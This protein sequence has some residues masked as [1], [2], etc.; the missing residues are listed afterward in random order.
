[1][2]STTARDSLQ[3]VTFDFATHVSLGGELVAFGGYSSPNPSGLLGQTWV[4]ADR[5]TGP[6]RGN[7]YMLASVDPF[8]GT[9]PLDVMFSRSTDGGLTWSTPVRVNDDSA[10][11]AWQWFGTMSVA[12]DGRIDVV[13]LDTRDDPGGL[14]S[15]LYYS[16]STDAGISW[17]VNERLSESFDPH[18][19]WP[20]QDK[21]G[22]YFDMKS[23]S[24]GAHLAWAGTFNGE[25][26]V[27]YAHITPFTTG[28]TGGN[29]V[30]P[31]RFALEQNYPNPF[32]PATEIGYRI[33]EAGLVTLVVYDILGREV[34]TLVNDIREPGQYSVTWDAAGSASGT[35]FY[36]MT[37]GDFTA[38]K[39]LMLLR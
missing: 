34:A 27:Y 38:T 39:R 35:Y 14:N 1:V 16:S 31:S 36:R 18:V 12:P 21:M 10:T 3:A 29:P 6:T 8:S 28:I 25:Q 4:A 11:N 9:D 5:S 26:D 23:D 17:S 15:S 30:L 13:W 20:Q 7:V 32:N 22:D 2:K 37:A 19:G 24:T 33:P